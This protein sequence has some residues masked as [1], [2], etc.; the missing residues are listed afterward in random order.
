MDKTIR[1]LL[2]DDHAI[3]RRRIHT[4]LDASDAVRIVGEARDG[5]EAVTL[6]ERLQ[7]DVIIMDI[8]M[9][10]LDG[11]EAAKII[12]NKLKSVRILF[13][14]MHDSALLAR[15]ALR[16]GAEGYV[17]KRQAQGELLT[18]LQKISTGNIYLSPA[19]KVD[20]AGDEP[21]NH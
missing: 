16:A 3:V 18:A 5:Q 13:L 19:L 7:P 9:P 10:V 12:K 17:L 2:A 4:V 20:L 1:V 11:F 15:Q 21:P 8:S 6:A 14:T